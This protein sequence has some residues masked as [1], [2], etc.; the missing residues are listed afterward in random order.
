MVSLVVA[1]A[2]LMV[3]YRD[4]S[5]LVRTQLLWAILAAVFI[6]AALIPFV[7][8]RYVL[9]VD[10]SL[11]EVSAL[12]VQVASCAFPLAAAFA[13]THYRL[14]DID[15]LVGRSLVIVPVM[16]I[17]AG[18]YAGTVTLFQQLFV[19]VTGTP[20]D[21]ALVLTALVLAAGFTP[22]RSLV[23]ELV[24]RR[25]QPRRGMRPASV[26]EPVVGAT[27]PPAGVPETVNLIP[28]DAAG[29]VPCPIADRPVP[30]T[31]CLECDRLRAVIRDTEPRIVC[32]SAGPPQGAAVRAT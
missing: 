3:R 26:G 20:S 9:P 30:L 29:T 4:G 24:R 7:L 8:F 1:F 11:G 22:I 32:A 17:L 15:V 5:D 23:E 10:E 2:S 6:I 19:A 18:V 13:V 31:T 27:L 21:F 28:V 12:F 16:A 14:Y 25:Y